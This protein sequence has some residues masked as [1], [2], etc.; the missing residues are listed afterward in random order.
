MAESST[1]R[2]AGDGEVVGDEFVQIDEFVVNV[3]V[4]NAADEV[5]I[6]HGKIRHD[7]GQAAQLKGARQ[8]EESVATFHWISTPRVEAELATIRTLDDSEDRE[9]L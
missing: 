8:I 5:T 6:L 7:L 4:T 9:G 1:R 2:T 3:E